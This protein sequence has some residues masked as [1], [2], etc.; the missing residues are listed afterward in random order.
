M[1]RILSRKLGKAVVD[2]QK[3]SDIPYIVWDS[4]IAGFGVRVYP[5]GRKVFVYKY[6]VGGG[7]SGRI[8]WVT[9]GVYG[10]LT[11]EQARSIAQTWSAEVRLGGDPAAAREQVRKAPT[12][13]DLL[14]RYLDEHVKVR[15]KAKTQNQVIDLV[16]R[17]IRPALGKS[18]VSD[19]SRSD[20]A[21]FHSS[22][23]ATPVT[24]NRALSILSKMFNLAEV[25][26]LRPEHS[27]PCHRVEKF[28]EAARNRF[29]TTEE[30]AAL[31]ETL[32][33]AERD[34]LSFTGRDGRARSTRANPEAVRAIRL[35]LFTGMRVGEVRSLRW[36]HLD[37]E[38]RVANLPDSKTGAKVVQLPLP[39]LE[40]IVTAERPASGRGFVVRGGNG[41][42]PET[43]LVNIKDTW[44]AIR[45]VAGIPDVRPHDLRH[46]FASVGAAGGA[47]LPVIGGLLGHSE[48]RTTQRYAHLAN[49]PLLQAADTIA[50]KIAGQLRVRAEG[51]ADS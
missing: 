19:V 12:V 46:A 39:A 13:S 23:A 22:R 20:I 8:R 51:G 37:L 27:N 50:S 6:R 47:S 17:L 15:N 43:P 49:D 38:R 34:T 35:M 14:D 48:A 26:G 44:G 45:A 32:D 1:E 10:S 4:E 33:R 36:E 31:G 18:K 11:P 3:P 7:R 9:V 41:K 5:S 28:K 42:D 30:F 24:A 2:A 29:L 25:W 16:E 40:V 21:S